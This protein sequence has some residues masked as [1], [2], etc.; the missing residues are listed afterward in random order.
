MTSQDVLDAL[1]QEF[2]EIV[3]EIVSDSVTIADAKFFDEVQEHVKSLD[4]DRIWDKPKLTF[5]EQKI[6]EDGCM[7]RYYDDG[8]MTAQN[9]LDGL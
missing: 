1:Q 6:M 5:F 2:I 4:T 9:V 8:L 3:D 7:W